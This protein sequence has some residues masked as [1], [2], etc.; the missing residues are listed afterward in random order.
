MKKELNERLTQ[1]GAGTPMGELFRRF[2]LPALLTSELNGPDEEAVPLRILGEDLVAF[3][4]TDGRLGVLDAHC[5]HRLASLSYGRNEEC[6]LRCIYHGWKFDV[7]GNCVDIPSE[8]AASQKIR[9]KIKIKSYPTLERGGAIWIYMGPKEYTPPFPEYEWARFPSEQSAA[10]KRFQPCNYAQALEGGIDSAHISFLHRDFPAA[11]KSNSGPNNVH[12]KFASECRNPEFSVN[13]TNYGL[14]IIA[15]RALDNIDDVY[16][17]VTQFLVPCFQMIPPILMEGRLKTNP[18]TGNVWVPIDDYN[19]WNW[20]F[21]SDA[22]ALTD[23]Q[24][25]LLGPEGIWG[26][27]DD[28][29][30]ALQ[31]SS[32]RYMFDL[33]RQRKTNFSGIQ[34]VRN[35]DAAVV[36]SMGP[37]VDRTQEHLGHS[38]S[39]IAMFRRL[40]LRLAN[41]LADGRE[42]D[43]AQRAEAFNIRSVSIILDKSEELQDV[44]P[45]AAAGAPIEAEAAE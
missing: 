7:E 43:A 22:E 28:N 35:Q 27:L 20:G 32:N 40:M 39:G 5:P 12:G 30:H 42:P 41:E 21:T 34:G 17:R 16:Y 18:T 11:D 9:D 10:I 44:L 23:Q 13:E 24:K 29:Y 31:N 38:D 14:Q 6:G 33:E 1:I 19:T 2:W 3:R 25:K 36:E 26:D 15:K 37:I 4:D 45:K 8:P